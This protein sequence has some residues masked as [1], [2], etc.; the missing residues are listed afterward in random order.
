[1]IIWC[2]H[3]TELSEEVPRNGSRVLYV[4]TSAYCNFIAKG[5]NAMLKHQR[6]MRLPSVFSCDECKYQTTS[7]GLFK[8]HQRV[9]SKPFK[10]VSSFPGCKYKACTKE[11]LENH[12][13]SANAHIGL[14]QP[15]KVFA[16]VRKTKEKQKDSFSC[17]VDG[18]CFSTRVP[19]AAQ[20]HIKL[21]EQ[22][23][24]HCTCSECDFLAADKENVNSESI[25]PDHWS[26]HSGHGGKRIY[27]CEYQDCSYRS[28]LSSSR[29]AEHIRKHT[30]ERPFPCP[31]EGCSY[32]ANTQSRLQ[33]HKRS[34]TNVKPYVCDHEGCTYRAR[35]KA[36]L[37][38]HKVIHSGEKPFACEFPGCSFRAASKINVNE[39]KYVHL[40]QKPFACAY[41]GCTYQSTRKNLIV[42]H[43]QKF[44]HSTSTTLIN[45]NC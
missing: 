23:S 11:L 34:H 16:G 44:G 32:K 27:I 14:P 35:Q 30:K 31:F 36:H 2:D 33:I 38:R 18:C 15:R 4:C 12:Q 41:P 26:H 17:H 28:D 7:E 29:F 40:S 3:T 43:Q 20:M 13:K 24:F 8:R 39:H 21:H 22:I 10:C 42:K 1:M 45:I 5:K 25:V 37:A 6:T 9:H 19:R